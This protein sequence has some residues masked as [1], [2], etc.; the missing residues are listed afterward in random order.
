V[1]SSRRAR[2]AFPVQRTRW[3]CANPRTINIAKQVTFSLPRTVRHVPSH[4]RRRLSDR[5][6]T[7]A[8]P[9][10]AGHYLILNLTLG[11]GA[12]SYRE[13]GA[14]GGSHSPAKEWVCATDREPVITIRAVEETPA[15]QTVSRKFPTIQLQ[16]IR[17]KQSVSRDQIT[18]GRAETGKSPSAQEDIR[19]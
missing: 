15:N 14:S 6:C 5:V 12:R 8:R 19:R 3:V 11:R 7:L 18:E 9:I 16:T 2:Q 13:Q 10:R 17:S 1:S 4:R